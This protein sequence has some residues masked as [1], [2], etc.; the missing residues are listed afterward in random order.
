M[1]H[2]NKHT[3]RSLRNTLAIEIKQKNTKSKMYCVRQKK[4][5]EKT[6][7]G[8]TIQIASHLE[9][10]ANNIVIIDTTSNISVYKQRDIANGK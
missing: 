9:I 3:E 10:A 7:R 8:N 2:V 1:L 4:K 5:R 6:Q